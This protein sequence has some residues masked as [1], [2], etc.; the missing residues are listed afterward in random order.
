ME[1]R[2]ESE[3]GSATCVAALRRNFRCAEQRVA[4]V[5]DGVLRDLPTLSF[6]LRDEGVLGFLVSAAGISITM[7]GP[8]VSG[9]KRYRD[10]GGCQQLSD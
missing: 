8:Y 3:A 1:V 2:E 10:V 6:L 7:V 4:K 5:E 9:G